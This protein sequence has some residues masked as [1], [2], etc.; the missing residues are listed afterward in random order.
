MSPPESEGGTRLRER[1][2]D[3]PARAAGL[4]ERRYGRWVGVVALVI[5]ALITLNTILTKPNGARGLA[6][7]AAL[8]PFAVP[9]A[10]SS[11][12]GGANVTT[13]ADASARGGR[14]ACAVRGARILNV[15]ALYENGPVVLALFVNGGGCARVLGELQALAPAFPAVRFAAVSIKGDRG[16]LRALA[17]AERLSFPLGIDE[18][19]V[20]VALYKDVS[21]PQLTFAYPGGVVQGRT[22]LALP[23]RA[24]LRAR[25]A[26]LLAASRARGWRP[27][28]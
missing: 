3:S 11:L 8:P 12:V 19:G 23:T 28:A 13:R 22:L 16:A 14:P 5:L 25:I 21:C 7:G 17:R 4:P 18:N 6:A 20:L 15:C 27:R 1:P 24:A 9:L 2:S 26:Q 10:T